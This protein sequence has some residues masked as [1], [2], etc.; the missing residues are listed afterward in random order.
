MVNGGTHNRAG[1][2]GIPSIPVTAISRTKA[3]DIFF[4]SLIGGLGAT[5]T[6]FDMRGATANR[7]TSLCGP[8]DAEKIAT[9]WDA[10]GVTPCA[11]VLPPPQVSLQDW[12][13]WWQI[14][15]IASPGSTIHV[16]QAAYSP[17]F[18][19]PRTQVQGENPSCLAQL[20][21]P[22]YFRARACNACGCSNW[23]AIDWA[24]AY[25][26]PCP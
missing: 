19:A 11:T 10:V 16:L 25:G 22:T 3:E 12:C 15:V 21:M 23:G 2:N 6:F 8:A 7:A 20:L 26:A 13:P 18:A 9:A 5:S 17:S 4:Q 14:A 1:Q 24:Q